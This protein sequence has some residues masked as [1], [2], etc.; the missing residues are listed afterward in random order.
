MRKL[1]HSVGICNKNP[2]FGLPRAFERIFLA[3]LHIMASLSLEMLT[4]KF[5]NLSEEW[6]GG[7]DLHFFL[8]PVFSD[9][10]AIALTESGQFHRFLHGDGNARG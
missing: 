2:V 3:L 9:K 6:W 7:P 5:K 4:V 8:R 1:H 10:W